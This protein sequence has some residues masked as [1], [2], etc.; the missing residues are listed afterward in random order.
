MRDIIALRDAAKQALDPA[1]W[2]YLEAGADDGF[3]V[4][5]AEPTWQNLPLHPHIL[6]NVDSV[7]LGVSV[8]G[9]SL[10]LPILT[11]PNGRATRYHPDGELAMMQGVEAAGGMALLPSSV[12]MSLPNLCEHAPHA[13]IWQQLYMTRD[14]GWMREVLSIIRAANARAVVLTADLLPDGRSGPPMPQPAIW[15]RAPTATAQGIF[16]AASMD[17][18]AWLCAEAGLPVLV[19]GVL[20]ADDA[21]HCVDVGAAGLIVSNH[22]G[23]QL[24]T[25][26]SVVDALPHIVQAVAGRADILVD[27]GIRRGTS[28]LKALA[29]GA[30][31]VLVGRPTSYALAANGR[32]GVADMLAFL[33]SELRRSM[34]LCG[35]C[36]VADIDPSLLTGIRKID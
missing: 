35:V 19:K 32:V 34:M 14:R 36:C 3:S 24:D 28:I 17:D 13:R 29:L 25:A 2:A 30:K 7:D 20:R 8:L 16:S 31:A 21:V 15:E 4:R 11:A 26:V 27:G 18:L 5:S 23:N 33:A 9:E 12:V 10:A 22:G 6:Q 1:V